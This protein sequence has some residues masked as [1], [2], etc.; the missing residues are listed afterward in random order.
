MACLSCP[1]S[2]IEN[3]ERNGCPLS[4]IENLERNGCLLSTIE[5]LERHGL[6]ELSSVNYRESWV[7]WLRGNTDD[8]QF[9]KV[10]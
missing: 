1:L 5:S 6:L 3:L 2:T 8:D 7:G 9:A 10:F 4:T